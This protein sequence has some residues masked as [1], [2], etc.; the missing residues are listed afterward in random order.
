M[1]WVKEAGKNSQR[2]WINSSH[3]KG[4]E[5]QE[6]LIDKTINELRQMCNEDVALKPH[7]FF[8]SELKEYVQD[9]YQ[10]DYEMISDIQAQ[11]WF[12]RLPQHPYLPITLYMHISHLVA[13]YNHTA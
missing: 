9:R 1:C 10:S 4:K 8:S 2:T 12:L 11:H 5:T 3:S 13:S 7:N 6:S